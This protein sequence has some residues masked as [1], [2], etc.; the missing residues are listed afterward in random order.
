MVFRFSADPYRCQLLLRLNVSRMVV[1]VFSNT[2]CWLG[3]LGSHVFMNTFLSVGLLSIQLLL[4]GWY[5]LLSYRDGER[6]KRREM[7]MIYLVTVHLTE[8]ISQRGNLISKY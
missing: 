1:L 4:M 3:T 8:N 7:V 2:H 6:E 5:K